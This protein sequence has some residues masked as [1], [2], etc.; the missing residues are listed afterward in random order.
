MK[1]LLIS[2]LILISII[3]VL[4]GIPYGINHYLGSNEAGTYI[5]SMAFFLVWAALFI[6]VEHRQ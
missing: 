6:L 3:A 2:F 4:F 1:A 5:V